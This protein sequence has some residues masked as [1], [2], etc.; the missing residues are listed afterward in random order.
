[1]LYI[2]LLSVSHERF[3]VSLDEKF[4]QTMWV[5]FPETAN[6]GKGGVLSR[7]VHYLC[8][9]VS[10]IGS[11]LSRTHTHTHTH[12]HTLTHTH[13]AF[14][15]LLSRV[16]DLEIDDW[17]PALDSQM[18]VTVFQYAA[19]FLVQGI[20]GIQKCLKDVAQERECIV[21]IVLY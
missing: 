19:F 14:S 13:T 15:E 21:S 2:Q 7:Y 5:D 17:E 1:M 20:S 10:C 18:V 11:I 6:K 3:A 16:L 8:V 12:T 9:T 4:G